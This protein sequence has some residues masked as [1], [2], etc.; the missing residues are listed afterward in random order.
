[1]YNTKTSQVI[2]EIPKNGSRS[3]VA[4]AMDG[5][6]KAYFKC[7]GHHT[8]REFFEERMP[9]EIREEK[10]PT[11]PVEVIAVI[12]NPIERLF[13]QVLHNM[14]THHSRDMT[15]ALETCLMQSDVV[16]KPQHEFV[17]SVPEWG[18]DLRLW[19]M[20]RIIEAQLYVS[21]GKP[22]HYHKNKQ[23]GNKGVSLDQLMLH[24][25]YDDA[26]D[27]FNGDFSLWLDAC[28]TDKDG[29]R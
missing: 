18:I 8:L 13:S 7:Q 15:K 22:W 23:K 27:I 12:R 20:D 3:L 5:T 24:N 28:K 6:P 10:R 17:R 4:A 16:F 14:H 2:L 1:M 11:P 9:R 25:L 19:D 29:K 21:G 26:V